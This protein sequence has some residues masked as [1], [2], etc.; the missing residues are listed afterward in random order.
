MINGWS[1]SALIA[2]IIF[3]SCGSKSEECSIECCQ[4]KYNSVLGNSSIPVDLPEQETK[5]YSSSKVQVAVTSSETYFINN[6]IVNPDS[7]KVEI[8]KQLD[9]S[10]S[11]MIE[12]SGDKN[13]RWEVIANLMKIAEA[14]NVK[15]V[16][17]T[18]SK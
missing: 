2:I 16:I 6:N 1:F 11:D 5:D 13:C 15:V 18:D 3:T 9:S 10:E 14:I 7:L 4:E 12:I 17:K 8:I